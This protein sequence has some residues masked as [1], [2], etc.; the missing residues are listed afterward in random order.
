MATR[1]LTSPSGLQKYNRK[2]K[3]IRIYNEVVVKGDV[4]NYPLLSSLYARS[5]EFPL[6]ISGGGRGRSYA[7]GVYNPSDV[8]LGA[9]I[10][11]RGRYVP[12]RPL[13]PGI[14][15]RGPMAGELREMYGADNGVPERGDEIAGDEVTL[16]NRNG[17]RLGVDLSF[18]L[19]PSRLSCLGGK[20]VNDGV[21]LPTMTA[22]ADRAK[23]EVAVT[24]TGLSSPDSTSLNSAPAPLN[25][26]PG[27]CPRR[28][29]SVRSE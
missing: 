4:Q 24:M 5:G 11:N 29:G 17:R 7:P 14:G 21:A 12:D 15:R 18:S 10:F 26:L 27:R 3:Y 23:A 16:P 25:T 20:A 8:L 19:S 9:L 6:M 22:F 13:L 2:Y 1:R 28:A